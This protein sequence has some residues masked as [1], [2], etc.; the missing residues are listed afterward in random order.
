[1]LFFIS[2]KP[3]DFNYFVFLYIL[4]NIRKNIRNIVSTIK[5]MPINGLRDFILKAIVKEKKLLFNETLEIKK[6]YVA[7]NQ[8]NR[9]NT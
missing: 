7:C 9:K 2:I 6:N 4:M 8:I 3:F 5:M 1:M